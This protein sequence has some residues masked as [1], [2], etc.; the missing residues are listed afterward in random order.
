MN[1]QGFAAGVSELSA[2]VHKLSELLVEQPEHRG[3][4][5]AATIH[6]IAES[7][8]ELAHLAKQISSAYKEALAIVADSV[9]IHICALPER[10]V[11]T[12]NPAALQYISAMSNA[13]E[14]MIDALSPPAD[15]S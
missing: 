6:A 10:G 8:L 12:N 9:I 1:I 15:R 7:T 11:P 13:L 3:P 5:D 14:H 2:N 4:I